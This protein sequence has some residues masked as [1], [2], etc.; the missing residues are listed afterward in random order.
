VSIDH[1]KV[2]ETILVDEDYMNLTSMRLQS[3]G[4]YHL[5]DNKN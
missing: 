4:Y 2:K 3:H 1:L 5:S